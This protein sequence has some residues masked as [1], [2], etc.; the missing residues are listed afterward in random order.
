VR[1]DPY[2]GARLDVLSPPPQSQANST[3]ALRFGV[4]LAS[5]LL[6]A[7]RIMFSSEKA[8]TCLHP[9]GVATGF[10]QRGGLVELGWRLA[11]PFMISAEK[12]AET[13][14]FLATIADATPFNGGYVVSKVLERPD[15]A[16]LDDSLA[17]RLWDES[18]RLVGP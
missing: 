16:A 2:P 17:R 3:A 18:A 9:G 8:A 7:K 10:G 4:K 1:R 15:P 12:G 5:L 14:L 11:K 13:T 6:A